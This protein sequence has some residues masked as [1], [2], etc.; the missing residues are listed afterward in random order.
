MKIELIVDQNCSSPQGLTRVKDELGLKL[1]CGG[2]VTTPY[3]SDP[4]RFRTLGIR[5]L[6]AWLVDGVV[7]KTNPYDQESLLKTIQQLKRKL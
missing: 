5:I 6:P 4:A 3:D 7:L 1:D 2:I